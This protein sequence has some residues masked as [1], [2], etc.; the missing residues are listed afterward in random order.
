MSRLLLYKKAPAPPRTF[1]A[2]STRRTWFRIEGFG[3]EISGLGVGVEGFG[4]GIPAVRVGDPSQ[5]VP[6]SAPRNV[7]VYLG[8]RNIQLYIEEVQKCPD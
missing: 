1:E 5:A 8:C 6:P 3:S 4:L 2:G 7:Q